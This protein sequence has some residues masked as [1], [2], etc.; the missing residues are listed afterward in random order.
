MLRSL[1]D[2]AHE[3]FTPELTLT[4]APPCIFYKSPTP[5]SVRG[6]RDGR[7]LGQ[8]WVLAVGWEVGHRVPICHPNLGKLLYSLPPAPPGQAKA[9]MSPPPVAF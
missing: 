5:Q 4:R 7:V 1:T 8:P 6:A 9:A 3:A 2:A